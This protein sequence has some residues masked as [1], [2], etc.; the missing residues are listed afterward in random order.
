MS[1]KNRPDPNENAEPEAPA[2]SE[3]L[4][5]ALEAKEKEVQSLYDQLLRLKAEFEN[6][7]KRVDRE[8]P[9]WIQQGKVSLLERLLPLYDVLLSAHEHVVRSQDGGDGGELARG[10]ELIFKEFTKLFEAE[11]VRV[12]E[13]VG[14]PYDFNLHEALG[15]V[16]TDEYPDGVVAAEL[17]RGYTLQGKVLRPAKVH[18]AKNIGYIR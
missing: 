9:E 11:G 18:I 8:R 2:A 15:H 6:F 17:Q 5:A 7:R 13:T 14:Q 3:E 4:S 10:L 16:E 1:A 12:I